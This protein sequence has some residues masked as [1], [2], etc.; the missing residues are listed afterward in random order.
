MIRSHEQLRNKLL[1][2][3]NKIMSNKTKSW[4][5]SDSDARKLYQSHPE[6][7]PSLETTFGKSF[8][9]DNILDRI[10]SMEDAF[11]YAGKSMED[12]E[13]VPYQNPKNKHQ[14]AVNAM[15]KLFIGIE[16]LNEGEKAD[17]ANHNTYKYAPYLRH[18]GNSGF[19]LSLGV[20]GYVFDSS[21]SVVGSRLSFVK[22]DAALRAPV[23]YN[24]EYNEAML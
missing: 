18:D 4:Q 1:H 15:A 23:I 24:K 21:G 11:E 6:F 2:F 12:P 10:T 22:R 7:R 9:S 14:V 8:F 17:F 16:V 19:G 20:I 13:I 3:K 5:L